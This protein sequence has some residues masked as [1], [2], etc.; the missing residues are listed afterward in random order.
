MYSFMYFTTYTLASEMW[1]LARLLPLMI[2]HFVP[3]D[4]R[5]WQLFLLFRTI[6][7]YVFAPATTPDNI[8]YVRGLISDYLSGFFQLHPD[9]P[10]IPKQHYLVH[11]PMWMEK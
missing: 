9:C 11:V 5:H 7:D 4:D 3:E 2:G 6:M 1:C 8:A 10:M